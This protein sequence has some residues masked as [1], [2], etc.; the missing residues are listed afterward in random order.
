M[1]KKKTTMGDGGSHVAAIKRAFIEKKALFYS[2]NHHSKADAN[3][4]KLKQSFDAM[5]Y[6]SPESLSTEHWAA[7]IPKSN[8]DL[9][10]H[11]RVYI[12]SDFQSMHFLNVETGALGFYSFNGCKPD[13][14]DDSIFEKLG[15]GGVA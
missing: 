9:F 14:S 10:P 12:S 4:A 15:F 1:M 8:P 5:G 6:L 3:L 2:G 7:L 11:L 13:Y